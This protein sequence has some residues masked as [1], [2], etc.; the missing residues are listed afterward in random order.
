M[1]L[2]SV[3]EELEKQNLQI[4]AYKQQIRDQKQQLEQLRTQRRR[5]M[6][7]EPRGTRTAMEQQ[8]RAA[9]MMIGTP[10]TGA[11]RGQKRGE[12]DRK[13]KEAEQE[14]KKY[15]LAAKRIEK[16]LVEL[17]MFQNDRME[18]LL[19]SASNQEAAADDLDAVLNEQRAY[20]RVLEEA[21]HL[22]ATDFEVTGH[23]ELLVV[24]A[25]LRHTIYEQEKDVEEKSSTLASLRQQLEQEQQRHEA[26]RRELETLQDQQEDAAHHLQL[27]E[28]EMH[29]QVEELRR[30]L[31]QQEDELRQLRES[32][33]DAQR[34]EEALQSRLK[35]TTKAHNLTQ[36]ELEDAVRSVRA[37]QEQLAT[38]TAQLEEAKQQVAALKDE[39]AKKQSHLDELN[40]LQE[41]LLGS[42]DKYASK[43]KRAHEK[44]DRL[45]EELQMCQQ[46]ELRAKTQAEEAAQSL[47][48]QLEALRRD[49]DAAGQREQQEK[50][51]YGALQKERDSLERTLA[52]AQSSLEQQLQES[53][54]LQQLA[55]EKETS[56]RQVRESV[57][58]L[59]AALGTAL[60]MMTATTDA[61]EL[62]DSSSME[63]HALLDLSVLEGLR[64]SCRALATLAPRQADPPY[65]SLCPLLAEI[66]ARVVANGEQVGAEISRALASWTRERD[67]LVEACATLEGTAQLCQDEMAKRHEEL[68]DYR[69]QL[70]E[71]TAEVDAYAMQVDTLDE[72]IRR[73]TAELEANRALQH[74]VSQLEALVESKQT[75]IA[76]L[77]AENERLSQVEKAYAVEAAANTRQSQ[78]LE[79]QQQA[80][81]EQR[82]YAEELERALES[83]A[84]FAE[85]Q[86]ECNRQVRS[87]HHC[88]QVL[89]V[90]ERVDLVATL[91]EQN[92]AFTSRFEGLVRQYISF[93]R[94]V[95]ATN[96]DLRHSLK[97]FEK[98]LENGDTL[99]L[100]QMFPALVEEFVA[101]S[102]G[103][104]DA[105][106]KLESPR[107]PAKVVAQRSIPTG[108]EDSQ[109]AEQLELIRDAFQSYRGV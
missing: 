26:T 69:A 85:Q 103:D 72:Q 30:R 93:L 71:R 25:E 36:V 104:P 64:A 4:S 101:T 39:C 22:K 20:I 50:D 8:K 38:A 81:A 58:E 14:K 82:D 56:C 57:A 105:P 76:D 13:L 3:Y 52:E 53:S 10:S 75:L 90:R 35:A 27:Q 5:S 84:T 48:E 9:Q 86:N 32:S 96:R 102:G 19:P 107:S 12:L 33:G 92:A 1:E 54:S 95:A 78:R 6:D 42:V 87:G 65:L 7:S 73:A 61:S 89:A 11:S 60:R 24:L 106:T 98:E 55:A 88:Y 28:T 41:E 51:R 40:T 37:T 70:T 79:S 97:L 34:R 68:L 18:S 15:Q 67:N 45:K 62:L 74:H 109:L 91:E 77:S 63:R 29:V 46:Q 23:E 49:V 66:I 59:E 83:A 44:A 16:A 108:K 99:A 17:Q 43:A 47:Q 2:T 100:L 21:V 31:Q 94:P 80:M